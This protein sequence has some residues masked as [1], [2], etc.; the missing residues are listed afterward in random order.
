MENIDQIVE[1]LNSC[2]SLVDAKVYL[3]AFS[4][5]ELDFICKNLNVMKG[6]KHMMIERISNSTTGSFLNRR[7]IL[8]KKS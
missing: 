4:L 8:G 5:N 1:K 6:S 7:A 2:K 3:Y